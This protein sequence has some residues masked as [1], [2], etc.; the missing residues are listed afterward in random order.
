MTYDE[1]VSHLIRLYSVVLTVC[2]TKLYPTESK[3]TL[4]GADKEWQTITVDFEFCMSG[5]YLKLY[6]AQDGMEIK[7][8]SVSLKES[9]EEEM[10]NLFTNMGE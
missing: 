2:P 6:F 5:F 8:V 10:K 7:N 1:L 3:N 9:K 4:T